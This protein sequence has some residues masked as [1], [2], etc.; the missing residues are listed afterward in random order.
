MKPVTLAQWKKMN[1]FQRSWLVCKTLG[2]RATVF[3]HV[4]QPD[5]THVGGSYQ[6]KDYCEFLIK[7]ANDLTESDAKRM[8]LPFPHPMKDGVIKPTVAFPQYAEH[9]HL[10]GRL[11]LEMANETSFTVSRYPEAWYVTKGSHFSHGATFEEAV[12]LLFLRI[13]SVVRKESK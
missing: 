4:H 9:A 12:C 2:E 1:A 10:A 13:H 6:S 11:I 7:A 5:G 8:D 3:W